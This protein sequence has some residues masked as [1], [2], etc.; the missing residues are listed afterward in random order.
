[1]RN[2]MNVMDSYSDDSDSV[3]SKRLEQNINLEVGGFAEE[4]DQLAQY[5]VI[6]DT[7]YTNSLGSETIN[8]LKEYTAGS[9][10]NGALIEVGGDPNLLPFNLKKQYQLI[11]RLKG[12]FSLPEEHHTYCGTGTF[13]PMDVTDSGI[14]STPS[15][16]STSLSIKVAVKTTNYRREQDHNVEDHVIHFILPA[17]FEGGFYVAPY[18]HDPEELEFLI[19]PKENFRHMSSRK[20]HLDGIQRHIHTYKPI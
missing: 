4:N 12:K 7:K 14:F 1:M 16:L 3:E 20:V 17:G 15:F 6:Q 9:E 5:Y 11:M 8:A 19:Y 2:L 10:I 18:S 13:N